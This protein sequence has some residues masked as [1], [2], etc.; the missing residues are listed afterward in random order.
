MSIL[1]QSADGVVHEFPNGTPQE[2]IDAAMR[3]YAQ[4][5]TVTAERAP[6]EGLGRI[7]DIA[8]GLYL[9]ARQPLDIAAAR[10]ERAFPGSAELSRSLGLRSAEDILSEQQRARAASPANISETIGQGVGVTPFLAA[11]GLAAPATFTQAALAGGTGAALTSEQ[12]TLGGVGTEAAFGAALGIPGKLAGDLIGGVLAP[13]LTEE[14]RRLRDL[15]VSL[16]P[17][18]V[19][20]A[21]GDAFGRLANIGESALTSIP[22]VGALID[23]ARG[24]TSETFERAALKQLGNIVGVEIPTNLQGGQAVSW[25]RKNISKK[26]EE[27]IPS[28]RMQLPGNW[29]DKALDIFDGLNLPDNRSELLSD[30]LGVIAKNVERTA[31]QGVLSG[32]NLQN[33]LSSLGDNARSLMKSSDGFSRRVGAGLNEFRSWLVDTLAEQNA[34]AAGSLRNLNKAWNAQMVLDKATS[35]AS[36]SITPTT[37]NRAVK[38]LN[39]GRVQG[40]YG[41][42]TEAGSAIP[43]SLQDSGTALRLATMQALGLGAAGGAGGAYYL[44]S[45]QA[46]NAESTV[47]TLATLAALYSPAGRRAAQAIL[48]REAGPV[49]QTTAAWVRSLLPATAGTL[50]VEPAVKPATPVTFSVTLPSGDTIPLSAPP[51]T[52]ADKQTEIAYMWLRQNR[53]EAI[54]GGAFATVEGEDIGFVQ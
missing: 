42:L 45:N 33:S 46:P 39:K 4:Q 20:G 14:V 9:G 31:K 6:R 37:L 23:Y 41:D 53:P 52:P 47:P 10:L 26:Y 35:Y 51:G 54:S 17:G 50:A 19:L 5:V 21:K 16:T 49:A 1:A 43:K 12:E 24:Q 30:Y 18:G 32:K 40:F 34:D 13:R 44:S 48:S 29:Q 3:D 25:L 22:G 8:E 36:D 38:S 27:L 28:L 15:G 7:A 11:A 2:V